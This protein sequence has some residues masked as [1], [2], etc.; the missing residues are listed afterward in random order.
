MMN[1][2]KCAPD[3]DPVNTLCDC[4]GAVCSLL[5]IMLWVLN[6]RSSSPVS[7]ESKHKSLRA[8]SQSVS[9]QFSPSIT[10]SE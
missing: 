5:V 4:I 1:T 3:K 7:S 2:S 9:A 8:L 10:S 6:K